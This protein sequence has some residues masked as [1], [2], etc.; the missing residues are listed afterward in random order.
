MTIDQ[1]LDTPASNANPFSIFRAIAAVDGNELNFL[2]NRMPYERFLQTAYWLAVAAQAKSRAG[3]HCQTC[4]GT[5]MISAHHRTYN[6]HGREH[7]HLQDLTCLCD[8]CHKIF[9]GRLPAP[10]KTES[11]K[12]ELISAVK[13]AVIKE[14]SNMSVEQLRRERREKTSLV[15]NEVEVARDMPSGSGDVRLTK[16][17]IEKC[18]T[19]R[20]FTNESMRWLGLRRPL[21]R[22]YKQGLV[23]LWIPRENYRK[24]LV[25]RGVYDTGRLETVEELPLA[26]CI[27]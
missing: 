26:K 14:N 23:G 8:Q 20:T 12:E 15:F 21:G 13:W 10:P 11:S 25:G 9:H 2:I 24:A 4:N 7:L 1:L 6:Y 16:E 3:M 22:D 18:R 27:N 5:R 19:N 17:L